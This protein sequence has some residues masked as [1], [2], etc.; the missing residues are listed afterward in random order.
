MPG[1]SA[2]MRAWMRAWMRA[3]R[4]DVAVGRSSDESV[5]DIA[6]DIAYKFWVILRVQDVSVGIS[7][8]AQMTQ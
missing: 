4:T 7:F 5:G 6:S 3:C 2:L 1:E 8:G